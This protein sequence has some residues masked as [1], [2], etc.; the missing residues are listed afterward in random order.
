M[1][2]IPP[3]G[4]DDPSPVRHPRLISHGRR[5]RPGAI[6]DTETEPDL[7]PLS[8]VPL[9][10]CR[11]ESHETLLPAGEGD[12]EPPL[13]VAPESESI[14][15][16]DPGDAIGREQQ[17]SEILPP[18]PIAAR[19]D[20]RPGD[21]DRSGRSATGRPSR[22]SRSRS[23]KKW[24]R[25][26]S[27]WKWR[28]ACKVAVIRAISE[29]TRRLRSANS[30]ADR[31]ARPASAAPRATPRSRSARRPSGSCASR[32]GDR[33]APR[34]PPPPEPRHPGPGRVPGEPIRQPPGNASRAGSSVAASRIA[35][36]RR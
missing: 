16:I 9:V 13:V 19:L 20:G 26:K 23:R 29:I 5:R 8:V 10:S 34:P 12:R 18:P 21:A 27:L 30:P 6:L 36:G 24:Q 11:P 7:P 28:A 2:P 32:H 17:L 14:A 3:D 31:A 4:F 1:V 22:S 15:V 33:S 25:Y 35:Q